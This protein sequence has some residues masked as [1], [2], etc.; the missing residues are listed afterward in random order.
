MAIVYAAANDNW[1]TVGNWLTVGGIPYGMLPQPNDDVYAN[2]KTIQLDVDVTVNT[3]RN[4]ASAP[5][6]AGGA[7]AYS[8]A[9]DRSITATNGFYN[10]GT[11]GLLIIT[12]NLTYTV[13]ITGDLN[14]TTTGRWFTWAG[15]GNINWTGNLANGWTGGY[16]GGAIYSTCTGTVNITGNLNP[17]SYF[18]AGVQYNNWAFSNSGIGTVN[19]TGL[20]YGNSY[21][22]AVYN[23][24]TGRVNITGTA[25][26]GPLAT[27]YAV[28][29]TTAGI[30]Q[31]VGIVDMQTPPTT[32][33]P[34]IYL[35]TGTL[36]FSGVAI[37]R[38]ERPAIDTT[39]MILLTSGSTTWT[40][41][42]SGVGFKNLYTAD[43]PALGNPLPANVRKNIAYG[44]VNELS[45]TAYMPSASSVLL[46]VPF[47]IASF[48][49]LLM[50]PADF[51]AELLANI[52]TPNSIGMRLKDC[53]TVDST[54]TQI[55]SLT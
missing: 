31:V 11:A 54:G 15:A 14:T 34:A 30:V 12:A 4:T 44:P 3:L 48:G 13:T 36:Y 2:G 49:T 16:N 27:A 47:D 6:V 18:S 25:M 41:Q 8:G 19:I 24:S 1:S 20:V 42:D 43:L 53:A 9:A 46:N 33:C 21:G 26:S 7:F 38:S 5:I 17:G 29:S 35:T 50:T 55:A 39:K 23:A 32:N 22:Y 37:N 10:T 52:T 28:Y 40:F 45:G 51:W